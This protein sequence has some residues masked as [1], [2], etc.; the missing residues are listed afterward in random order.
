V[1]PTVIGFALCGSFCTFEQV[2]KVL[3]RVAAEYTVIPIMSQNSASTD[4]RFGTADAFIKEIESI[5]KRPVI[6][7]IEETEPIGP[8]RLL[9]LL[10]IAPC[11]G[12]TIAKIA[13][14]ITDT[15]VT[16]AYKAH[17]RN[18]RP[19]LLAVSTNDALGANAPNIGL[20]L[21]R[22]HNYFVPF[23][24]DD[25]F[26]KPTSLTADFD[27][28]PEAIEAALEGRQLQPMIR[29]SIG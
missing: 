13:S 18:Q 20:L 21:N 10:V 23:Y 11:T 22:R 17:L 7:R 9:D 5:C 24:Q 16:M 14:G 29:Q 19:V 2:I 6:T 26:L 15:G 12:N 28:I 27:L 8:E 4:T 1:K 25:P 3:K